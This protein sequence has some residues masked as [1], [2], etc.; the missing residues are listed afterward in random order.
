[1][2]ESSTGGTHR[3]SERGKRTLKGIDRPWQLFAVDPNRR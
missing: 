3:F 2:V 1:V